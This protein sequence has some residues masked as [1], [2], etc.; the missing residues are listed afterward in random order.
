MGKGKVTTDSIRSNY[1]FNEASEQA[2]K[3]IIG[4]S[5]E[6]FDEKNVEENAPR[7]RGR[8]KLENREKKKG[9]SLTLL[10]STYEKAQEKAALEGRSVSEVISKL[11]ENYVK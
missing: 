5:E 6:S 3:S 4:K 8:K 1:G 10:P 2:L 9:Y 7:K 11:L